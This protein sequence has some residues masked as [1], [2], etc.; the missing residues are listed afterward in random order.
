MGSIGT[1]VFDKTGTVTKGEYRLVRCVGMTE[2]DLLQWVA[3]VEAMSEHPLARA[4]LERAM[5]LG[6]TFRPAEDVLR[7]DGMGVSGGVLGQEVFVGNARLALQLAGRIPEMLASAADACQQEGLSAVFAGWNGE[8]R[9]VLCCGDEI[10]GEAREAIGTL[11]KRG[12]HT[13]VLSGDGRAT[14]QAVSNEVGANEFEAEVLP[15]GKADFI[16]RVQIARGAVAMVGDGVNDAPALAQATLGIAM[17]SGAALAMQA[18][19]VVLMT[20]SLRRVGD[21]FALAERTVATVRR[22]LFW[23]FAY[24]AAGIA[25]AVTGLVTPFWAAGAMIISSVS[26]IVQSSWLARWEPEE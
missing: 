11:R 26:V 17:G 8:V 24:N 7:Y 23:A 5:G 13:I 14:T 16:R 15:E 2:A 4:I 20:S 1:V 10:R 12:L 25:L 9:A 22:N 3:P 21:A 19:P 18:A 6:L